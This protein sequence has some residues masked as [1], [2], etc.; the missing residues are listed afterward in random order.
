MTEYM[1]LRSQ[2]YVS[3]GSRWCKEWQTSAFEASTGQEEEEI[4][5]NE[6]LLVDHLTTR[7]PPKS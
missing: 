1:T 6:D 4:N 7:D 2:G 5:A 3:V